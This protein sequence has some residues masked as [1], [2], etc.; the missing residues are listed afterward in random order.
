MK[1]T[2]L[3]LHR[4]AALIMAVIMTIAML[5]A[6]SVSVFALRADG[7]PDISLSHIDKWTLFEGYTASESKPVIATNFETTGKAYN[8]LSL[9]FS[10]ILPRT[11]W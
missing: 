2:K 4:V 11:S 9:S 3:R 5:P 1:E 7:S 8:N 6:Q 10:A